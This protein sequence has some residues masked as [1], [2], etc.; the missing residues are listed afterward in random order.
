MRIKENST[1]HN[2]SYP[3]ASIVSNQLIMLVIIGRRRSTIMR[4]HTRQEILLMWTNMHSWSHMVVFILV[5]HVIG[6]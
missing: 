1:N 5:W 6:S 3:F 2:V 4:R